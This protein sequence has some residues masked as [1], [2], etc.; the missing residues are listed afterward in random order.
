MGN[1]QFID[2][3]GFSYDRNNE[4]VLF[5]YVCIQLSIFFD[6]QPNFREDKFWK[7]KIREWKKNFIKTVS[8]TKLLKNFLSDN[9][10]IIS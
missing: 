6:N 4:L 5:Q 7:S 1:D 10:I 9:A 2:K 3:Y 8:F